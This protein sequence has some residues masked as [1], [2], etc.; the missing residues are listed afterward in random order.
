MFWKCMLSRSYV[1]N[2]FIDSFSVHLGQ[3][4]GTMR[5]AFIWKLQ[6]SICDTY[7]R[8][9]ICNY[10]ACF[11]KKILPRTGENIEYYNLRHVS[12]LILIES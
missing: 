9:G 11:F 3:S 7:S 10:T 5:E 8:I 12:Q 6:L 4:K 1:K 2:V